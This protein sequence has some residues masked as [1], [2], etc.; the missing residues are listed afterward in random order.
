MAESS[1]LKKKKPRTGG[2]GLL[3][4]SSLR[5]VMGGKTITGA[6]T[7]LVLDK[8]RDFFTKMVKVNSL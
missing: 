7:T 4:E 5:G 6:N 8:S 2:S 3:P 1:P